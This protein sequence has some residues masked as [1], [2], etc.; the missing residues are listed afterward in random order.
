M[1][2][3]QQETEVKQPETAQQTPQPQEPQPKPQTYSPVPPPPPKKHRR[4][5]MLTIVGLVLIALL[6]GGFIGYAV[7]YSE[8]NSKLLDL[9]SQIG[10]SSG[11]SGDI[12]TY[13][14]NDNVSL[15]SL[16]QHVKSSV[17]VV[18][19]FVP[20]TTFFGARAYS[21]QQ[22]SGFIAL[23]NNQK[24][25][26]TN[27]HVVENAINITVTFADG[28][29]YPAEVLG[30]D[31]KADL[32][33]LTTSMP[34]DASALSLVSSTTLSVGDPVVALGSPYGLSGTLTTGVISSLGRT[35]IEDSSSSRSGQT[36]A[37]M[38]Q[39]S[40]AINPGNSGGPLLNYAGEVVGI[41]TAGIS[42]SESLGF[43]IPSATII[44]ELPS[45]V[46]TGS[47]DQHP[48]INSV[49]TDMTYSIAQAMGTSVTYGFLVESVSV[50]N[51]LQ[52]GNVQKV[53][54]S[55]TVILG[56]DIIIGVNNQRITNTDALLS[57][58]E[59]HALPGQTLSFTVVR[60]GQ[61]QNVSV[62]IGKA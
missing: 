59:Q 2:Q 50:Q 48:S 9:Q 31:A 56:G 11:I 24:V 23:V 54:G 12:Q 35:I 43:A 1:E 18:Q 20:V 32:A 44:R 5:S 58:L 16:Y 33:V 53:V 15:A 46:S 38:I 36:I 37:D 29:S 10:L 49:G 25:I 41:T 34:S 21:S 42:D 8:F 55:S 27:N 28:D 57:Y 19:D 14:L 40:T 22:G 61:Q 17:V 26:V 45:L 13:V 52:G 6:A 4:F 62:T 3:P 7:T 47:Y 51:G 39:T 60:D 30:Q